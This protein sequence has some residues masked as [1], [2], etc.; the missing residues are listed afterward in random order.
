[1]DFANESIGEI[2]NLSKQ[3]NFNNLIYNF[4]GKNGPKSFIG[5]KGPLGFYKNIKDGYTTLEKAEESQKN[6]KSDINQIVKG[7]AEGINQKSK[8]V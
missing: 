2:Q 8:K 5:F 4:K 7:G 1:M 6:F 3:I